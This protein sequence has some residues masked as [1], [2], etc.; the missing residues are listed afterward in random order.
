MCRDLPVTDD[1]DLRYVVVDGITIS[2]DAVYEAVRDALR[3]DR[4]HIRSDRVYGAVTAGIEAAAARTDDRP[5]R[6]VRLDGAWM[7]DL[8]AAGDARY[9]VAG[10]L[11][12]D[13]DRREPFSTTADIAPGRDRDGRVYVSISTVTR[14]D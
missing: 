9:G 10:G 12:F 11:T 1:R 8:D 14:I 7:A 3:R 2:D 6:D 13:H 4:A 5:L